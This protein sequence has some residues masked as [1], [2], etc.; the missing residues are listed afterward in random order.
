[1]GFLI[2]ATLGAVVGYYAAEQRPG[3]SRTFGI[4]AGIVLGPLAWVLFLVP[5]F[6][7][8]A[9]HQRRCPYCAGSVASDTRICHHCH[10]I[11]TSEWE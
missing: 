11:L 5:G 2:W 10:A 8:D 9:V 7:V 4:V 3:L 6:A 1:M